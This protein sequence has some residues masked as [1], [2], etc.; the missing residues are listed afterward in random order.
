MHGCSLWYHISRA[1]S[2]IV[3]GL[4][5]FI[6]I[7]T[8]KTLI[9]MDIN[10]MMKMEFIQWRVNTY[11]QKAETWW[12]QDNLCITALKPLCFMYKFQS[13]IYNFLIFCKIKLIYSIQQ[14]S[15]SKKGATEDISFWSMFLGL[16]NKG[17]PKKKWNSSSF[18]NP[19]EQAEDSIMCIALRWPFRLLHCIL[20]LAIIT[21]SCLVPMRNKGFSLISA[22]K[23][24]LNLS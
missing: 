18:T 16:L 13:F 23:A 5:I 11:S 6:D 1:W 7:Q 14:C 22:P 15:Q 24:S 17:H 10:K 20:S 4:N 9:Q 19:H 2:L 12:S 21:C 8:S 3:G